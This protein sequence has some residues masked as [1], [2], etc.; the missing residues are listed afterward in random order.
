MF[1]TGLR[2]TNISIRRTYVY[3]LS[4]NS[5]VPFGKRRA[6]VSTARAKPTREEKNANII[7]YVS[8]MYTT[9]V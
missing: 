9:L 6:S 2:Y 5:I 7:I 8:H 4:V 1:C 3:H